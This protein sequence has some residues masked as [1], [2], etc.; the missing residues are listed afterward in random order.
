MNPSVHDRLGSVV[1]ALGTVILP[2]LPASASLAREQAML[3]MGHLQ[4]IIAQLDAT[5]AFEA[6]E[7]ADYAELAASIVEIAKGGD[8]TM[9]A[10]RELEAIGRDDAERTS[11]ER[12]RRLQDAIDAL[13]EALVVDGD[14]EAVAT[15]EAVVLAR[16]AERARKDR[17]WFAAM[18]FD[19]EHAPA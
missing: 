11:R 6:E 7:A 9:S 13:L 12:T 3:C 18:G 15:V 8:A 1:R 17:Q 4:I 10:T 5:P 14:G 19:A 2:A 16:G